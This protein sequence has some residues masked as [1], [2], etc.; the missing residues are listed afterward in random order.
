MAGGFPCTPYPVRDIDIMGSGQARTQQ[1]LSIH[2]ASLDPYALPE[3]KP[4]SR[5]L[6]KQ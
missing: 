4:T 6:R 5:G 2:D 3:S 1:M